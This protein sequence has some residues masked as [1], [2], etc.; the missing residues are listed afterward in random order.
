MEVV[1][2]VTLGPFVTEFTLFSSVNVSCEDVEDRL[3]CV[4]LREFFGL[5]LRSSFGLYTI[6]RNSTSLPS[7][8]SLIQT[9][10]PVFIGLVGGTTC[11][12]GCIV[13]LCS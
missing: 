5:Q 6:S 2:D 4:M 9:I 8:S 7:L 11:T 10:S 12:W 1:V 13:E 3:L